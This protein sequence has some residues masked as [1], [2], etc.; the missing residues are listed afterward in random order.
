MYEEVINDVGLPV[1]KY[2]T[3][4]GQVWWI[5]VD[6]RNAMYQEYLVWLSQR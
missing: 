3:E 5:P 6:E 4:S 1:I 2:T